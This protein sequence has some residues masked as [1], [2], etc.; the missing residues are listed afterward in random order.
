MQLMAEIAQYRLGNR[1]FIGVLGDGDLAGLRA[2]WQNMH[3]ST[4]TGVLPMQLS[5]LA[6]IV[7]DIKP[8]AAD[9]EKTFSTM[10]WIQSPVRNQLLSNKTTAM[11]ALK[12]HY[13]HRSAER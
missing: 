8:H 6:L 12:I 9:C 2:Y 5:A 10:N 11:A 1:P 13:Q 4:T 3:R 7:H